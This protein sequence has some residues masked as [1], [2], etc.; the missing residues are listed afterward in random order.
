MIVFDLR[1]Q[2]GHVF[3]AWFGSSAAFEEQRARNLVGCPVCSDTAVEK[4]VMAPN[5][6]PK[7]NT[8]TEVTPQ[9]VKAALNTLAAAQRQVLAG[10]QWVGTNFAKEARAMHVG[11]QEQAA[12]HGQATVQEAKALV[13]EG[14]P[15]VP[16]PLPVLPPEQTN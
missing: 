12:I 2:S 3:E 10:S 1:C 13:E 4:A 16:L 5:V 6:V 9:T 8:R 15:I 7:G 11:E 14:V